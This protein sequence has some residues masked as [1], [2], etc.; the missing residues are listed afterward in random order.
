MTAPLTIPLKSSRCKAIRIVEVYKKSGRCRRLF[1][2]DSEG[3]ENKDNKQRFCCRCCA[4]LRHPVSK[5]RRRRSNHASS[6][7]CGCRQQAQTAQ[8]IIA[9]MQ[10]RLMADKKAAQQGAAFRVD[11]FQ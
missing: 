2:G 8:H 6:R 10:Q 1:F 3:L 7:G 4:Q 5:R 11:Q 9:P